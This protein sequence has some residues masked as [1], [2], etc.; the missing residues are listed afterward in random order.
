[1]YLQQPGE[2]P[3]GRPE[4][5]TR[6]GIGLVTGAVALGVTMMLGALASQP[7]PSPQAG[8]LPPAPPQAGQSV[9]QSALQPLA[10]AVPTWVGIPAIGVDAPLMEV[11]LDA[12]GWVQ[13]PPQEHENL[14][15]WYGGSVTPGALGTAVIVGHVDTATGPAVF[16]G[17]GGLAAGD[18]VDVM[19]EDG[20]A[21]EFTIYE[22]AVFD[23]HS[24]PERVYRDT[25][26]AELR[27]I[28]C[29]GTYQDG[30]GYPSNIVVFA[31]LSDTR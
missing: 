24:L 18:A 12:E 29:G 22:V 3:E 30:A 15:G 5:A 25:D 26:H 4:L 6:L 13:A 8:G 1:M 11:G 31:R 19:R 2:P 9:P 14:A 27:I 28:T 23:K 10:A 17:L 7:A 20:T 21:A 16:Y